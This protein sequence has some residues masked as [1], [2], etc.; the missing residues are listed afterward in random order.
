[1]NEIATLIGVSKAS[2][3]LWVRDVVLTRTQRNQ[4]TARGFSKDAIEKRRL[5]RIAKT[6]TLHLNI[7]NK[8]KNDLQT[9]SRRELWLLGTALYWGEGGKTKKSIVRL[10]NSDPAVIRMT[11]RFF[12]EIISVP[13]EKFRCHVHTFSHLNVKKCER[14]W[15]QITK[16]P[17]GRFYKTYSKPS[18]AS[19]GKKDS[20][21]YGTVQ[22]YVCDTKLYLTLMGWIERLKEL[23][24]NQF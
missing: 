14:Y 7:L 24:L 8:A 2:V 12:R 23:S 3:S 11:M 13:E 21:P 18:V 17:L 19:Q 9:I 4:L 20:L 10:A 6:N 16:V 15:S 1:M 5:A 22:I